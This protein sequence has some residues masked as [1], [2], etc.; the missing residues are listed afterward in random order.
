MKKILPFLFLT[1]IFS[2]SSPQDSVQKRD[3]DRAYKSALRQLKKGKSVSKNKNIL[4]EA[5]EGI[6]VRDLR[7]KENLIQTNQLERLEEAIKVNQNLQEK[8]DKAM[9]FVDDSFQEDLANLQQ[10]ENELSALVAK[11]YFEDG[12]IKLTE[13]MAN[14]DK[15]LSRDAYNDF[16]KAKQ[17]GFDGRVIEPLLETSKEFSIVRYAVEANISFDI[18]RSWDIDREMDNLEDYNGR[19]VQVDFEKANN[20][21]DIDCYIEIN[22]E[23]L[24]IDLRE[25]TDQDDFEKEVVVGKKTITNDQGEEV[26]V[27]KIEEVEG[28]VIERT[29]TKTAEWRVVIDVRSNSKNCTLSGTYFSEA[30][31]SKI[32]FY[33]LSGDERAIPNRYKKQSRDELMEDDDMAEALLEVIY[34][35]VEDYIFD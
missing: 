24:D 32:S 10:E 27:D 6:L 9:A 14:N 25:Q 35:R 28:T 2:C 13:A 17:Y 22:F 19:F 30:L 1:F 7:K 8:I 34:E 4:T 11:T 21:N 16:L 5:L 26:E 12:D 3:F 31:V 29:I 33:E 18:G 23:S 15:L 20:P